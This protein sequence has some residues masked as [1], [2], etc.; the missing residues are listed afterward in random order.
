M[1]IIDFSQVYN[2]EIQLGQAARLSARI[3]T[4]GTLSGISSSEA[5][6]RFCVALNNPAF[7]GNAP[8]VGTDVVN[9]V[10]PA[11]TSS[12]VC[13][14]SANLARVTITIPYNRIMWSLSTLA[15][16]AVMRC[17]G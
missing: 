13:T 9:S 17:V 16:G 4:V 2:D 10:G 6:A 3:A 8:G 15:Q 12:A 14:D 7:H 5:I 1:R 11:V